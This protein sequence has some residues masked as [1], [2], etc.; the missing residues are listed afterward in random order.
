MKSFFVY[1]FQRKF[2]LVVV[3]VRHDEGVS[4]C[5]GVRGVSNLHDVRVLRLIFR[6]CVSTAF[7][8]REE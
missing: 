4:V 5:C 6:E 2:L 7:R 1:C 3:D 8:F